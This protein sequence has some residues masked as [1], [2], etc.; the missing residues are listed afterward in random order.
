M[1]RAFSLSPLLFMLM[2]TAACTTAQ[3]PKKMFH[4]ISFTS[5]DGDIVKLSQFKGKKI[6]LVNTA[7]RCGYTPQYKQLQELHEKFGKK[8]VVIGFPCSDFGGQEPGDAES[9]A[10][11]CEKNYGVDFLMADKVQIKGNSP[12]PIYQ[13]LTQKSL[14]GQA[15]ATVRWNF[16]KFLVDENG[17]LI[18]EF[19][20]SV[21][22]I[23]TDIT[24]KL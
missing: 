23:S 16:H 9:I 4:D 21:S 24:S 1:F 6:L 20:S 2:L 18:G 19:P 15:D 10:S 5:I 22:P 14:N 13:W 12:H 17:N 3:T 7:S 8:V 11:F